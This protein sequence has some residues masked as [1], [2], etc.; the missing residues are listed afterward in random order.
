MAQGLIILKTVP[1]TTKPKPLLKR[2]LAWLVVVLGALLFVNGLV[3]EIVLRLAA[4]APAADAD[5]GGSSGSGGSAVG[6][7]YQ[8]I[9]EWSPVFDYPW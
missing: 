4:T 3:H 5:A 8:S 2:A 6:K 7:G 9:E 1:R